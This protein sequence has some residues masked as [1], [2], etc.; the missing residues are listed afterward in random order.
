MPAVE[1]ERPT[2][3]SPATAWAFVSDMDRWAPL[4][5]GYRSH[6]QIDAR[7]SRWTVRGELGGLTRLA[8]FDV[9]VT[10]WIEPARIAFTLTGIDEPFA[11]S[12]TFVIT[13]TNGGATAPTAPPPGLW[14]RLRARIARW[15][16]GRVT[17]LADTA[18]P[19]SGG[20]PGCVLRCR[21]EIQASGGS[22][23]IMN[24]LLGPILEAVAA[25]TA[26]RIVATIEGRPMQ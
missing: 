8:E 7:H 1:I 22:G 24:L 2:T 26:T 11:G 19:Q 21:L 4:L 10:E 9:A 23:A 12:G 25:D 18:A 17:K 13:E 16:L 20:P 3:A 5:T 15:L 6:S 14:A